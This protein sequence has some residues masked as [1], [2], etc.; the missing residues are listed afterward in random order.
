MV[1]VCGVGAAADA[2]DGTTAP[3]YLP[4]AELRRT[5]QP[6]RFSGLDLTPQSEVP[7]VGLGVEFASSGEGKAATAPFIVLLHNAVGYGG[8]TRQCGVRKYASKVKW[9]NWPST[10]IPRIPTSTCTLVRSSP[11]REGGCVCVD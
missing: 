6:A 5:A 4:P 9:A 2:Y 7:T 10:V 8:D 3:T 1:C 11:G